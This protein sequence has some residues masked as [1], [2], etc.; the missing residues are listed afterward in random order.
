MNTHDALRFLRAASPGQRAVVGF[1]GFV[2]QIARVIA[3]R[4]PSGVH[5][6]DRIAD[7]GAM[8]AAASGRSFG[9]EFKISHVEG[10][11]NGPNF[12]DGLLALGFAVDLFAT[13]GDPPHPAFN[14]IARRCRSFTSI[15]DGYGL[16]LALEFADGKLM[17]N[18]TSPL[19]A[20]DAATMGRLLDRGGYTRACLGD[21]AQSEEPA[22]LIGLCNWSKYPRMTACWDLVRQRVFSRFTHAPWLLLDLSDPAGRDHAEIL[23]LLE[24]LAGFTRHTRVV[25]GVNLHEAGV[26]LGVMDRPAPTDEPGA[27]ESAAAALRARLGAHLVAVHSQRR[28]A[29]AWAGWTEATGW[30]P[31]AAAG[32]GS[33]GTVCVE[34]DHTSSPVRTTGVGDRFNAGLCAGLLGNNSPTASLALGCAA[35]AFFVRS[36]RP[37]SIDEI[38]TAARPA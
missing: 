15:G 9:R 6:V 23:G 19:A 30:T 21:P 13:A 28:A 24:L 31:D 2:D 8:I 17:M 11:G 16:T 37:G 10:G 27:M 4:D 20:L 12:A 35:G 7:F 18:E 36:G 33:E 25:L 22:Q 5:Y 1:D 14:D 32:T 3:R 29:A 38:T 26:L 34:T